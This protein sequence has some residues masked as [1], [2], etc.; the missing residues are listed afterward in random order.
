MIE[1]LELKAHRFCR[2]C[3]ERK[4]K[5]HKQTIKNFS[6]RAEREMMMKEAREIKDND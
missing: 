1:K 6:R 4:C 2:K 3:K 5:L